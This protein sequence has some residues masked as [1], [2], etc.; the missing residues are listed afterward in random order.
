MSQLH[1]VAIAA[2]DIDATMKWYVKH[3]NAKITY[4]DATWAL[5]NIGNTSIAFV[6]P[7][8]H[9]PHLAFELANAH[10]FGE[11]KKHRDGT[12]SIYTKDPSGNIVEIMLKK[13][14]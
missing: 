1:H 7:E 13:E 9:P 14:L 5:I 11:L 6:T 3:F 8:Q 2:I 12:S 4:Q 10:E